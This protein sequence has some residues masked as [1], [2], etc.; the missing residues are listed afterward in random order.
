MIHNNIVTKTSLEANT[1][2]LD[3]PVH[4]K[5][6]ISGDPKCKLN[7]IRTKGAVTPVHQAMILTIEPST[8]RYRFENDESWIVLQGRVTITL[9]DGEVINMQTGDVISILGGR[10]STWQ[11]FEPFKKFVVITAAKPNGT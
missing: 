8:F 4:P 3:Y 2:W 6:I 10:N 7:I 9:E 1:H 5:D 11:V